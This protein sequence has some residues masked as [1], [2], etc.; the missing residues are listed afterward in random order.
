MECFKVDKETQIVLYGLSNIGKR[1]C[2]ELLRQ[3]YSVAGIIDRNAEASGAPE[4]IALY[5]PQAFFEAFRG[6]NDIVIAICLNNGIQHEKVISM[7]AAEGYRKY[8][9]IPMDADAGYNFMAAMQKAYS[10]F[11]EGRYERLKEIPVYGMSEDDGTE[12]GA[13]EKIDEDG[14]IDEDEDTVTFLCRTD[15]LFSANE[16]M[17]RQTAANQKLL[18]SALRRREYL[19]QPVA[20]CGQ[21]HDLY[22]YLLGKTPYPDLYLA[23]FGMDDQYNENLL[24]DRRELFACYE[25][26]YKRDIRLFYLQ[27]ATV[28]WNEKGYFNI[29]DGLHRVVYLQYVKNRMEAPVKASKKDYER[30]RAFQKGNT[31]K[32]QDYVIDKNTEIY[33]YGAAAIG[34]I[35]LRN[36]PQLHICGF[37]DARGKEIGTMCEKPVFS[38]ENISEI[39]KDAV[40]IVTVKN[41][42]EHEDIAYRLHQAGYERIIY[43]P[44]A[45]LEGKGSTNERILSDLWDRIVNK[46]LQLPFVRTPLYE[47][48]VDYEFSDQAKIREEGEEI[49]AYV[50]VELIYT[51][52]TTD[53]WG[54][55][56]IQA[57]YPHIYFFRSLENKEGGE[58]EDYLEFCEGSATKLGD[59]VISDSWRSNVLR[60]RTM[61]YEQMSL[62]RDIDPDFFVRSAPTAEWNPKGY[63][64]LTGGKHRASYLTATGHRYLALKVSRKDYENWLDDA[65]ARALRERIAAEKIRRL[66]QKEL[67]P[68][69]YK[70]PHEEPVYYE[71]FQGEV[72]RRLCRRAKETDT[73]VR[74]RTN[75]D[76]NSSFYTLLSRSKFVRIL[77]DCC[78]TDE[79]ADCCIR[80]ELREVRTDDYR[81]R[82]ELRETQT[83]D[84]RIREKMQEDSGEAGKTECFAI[85]ADPAGRKEIARYLQ[86]GKKVYLCIGGKQ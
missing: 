6:R 25:K 15:V 37:I 30:Y 69:F 78:K 74:I 56:N 72:L 66:P 8:I 34:K 51:N 21:Y 57:L 33:C 32:Q 64:N 62:S 18:Q 79:K 28:R 47:D 22:D 61:I 63:F 19:E 44:K 9:Y 27:P 54:D 67:H 4:N 50:P 48:S 71:T 73:A 20:M 77:P 2:K 80:D 24:Q 59:I 81:I 11:M 13:D 65:A 7:L 14:I 42:F 85:T 12:G 39:N 70:F 45:V 86:N 55:I 3:G 82:D 5:T 17:L 23:F 43:K 35:V 1:Q 40:V 58:T 49:T 36:N 16:E 26:K 31:M 68:Y 53:F 10:Y 41:V 38:W 46:E 52:D 84:Y 75:I 60:N 29:C 76:A 83:D